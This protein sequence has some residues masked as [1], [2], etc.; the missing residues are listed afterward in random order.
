MFVLHATKKLLARIKGPLERDR[1][2]TNPSTTTSTTRLGDWTANLLIIRRQQ[3]V[4]AVNDTT[5][6]PVL[7]PSAPSKTF[8][9]RF[10]EAAGEVLMAIG[11]DREKAVSEMAA[12]RAC[13]V[14]PTNNRR[15]VGTL[16]DFGS[17]LDVYLDGRPLTDVALR[18][19]KA[20]CSPIGMERPT[21]VARDAFRAP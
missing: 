4:L 3:L 17:M 19:A 20:P 6:L 7:L 2:P 5:L 14:A 11:V 8:V 15:V 1:A 12:M 13:A 10:A 16:T 21:D 18:L 9:S